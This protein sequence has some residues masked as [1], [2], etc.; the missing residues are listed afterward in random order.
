MMRVDRNRRM[1]RAV[2]VRAAC[3]VAAALVTSCHRPP[4]HE[5]AP[6]ADAQGHT[7]ASA[8]TAAHNAEVAASLPLAD[9][10]DFA[11][12]RRG[13]VAGDGDV[14]IT[15]ADGSTVWDTTAYAFE[16]GEAPPSAN[17]SLWRQAALNNIHGLFQVADGVYQVRGYD[18]SN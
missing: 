6:G 2:S 11:D 7:A 12:A 4:T 15:R 17:P 1:S 5:P 9:Q 3:V 16:Q 13:L 8:T 14:V 18:L 10:Q